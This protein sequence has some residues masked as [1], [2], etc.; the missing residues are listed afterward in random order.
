MKQGHIDPNAVAVPD[1]GS[2]TN[3]DPLTLEPGSQGAPAA[4][5]APL[6]AADL[7]PAT[8]FRR[9][10]A[11]A[12]LA[13]P[14]TMSNW[15][16]VTADRTKDGHPIAVMGPQ[17]A[18]FMPQILMD[19]DVHAPGIAA[20]GATFP[21]ISLYVLLGRGPDFAWSATS[22][23][24]DETDVRA[25]EL[26]D[27]QGGD[28]SPDSTYYLFK[29][30]C[31]AMTLRT[32]QWLSKPTP[33]GPGLPTL[34]TA[35][36]QRTI[37][38]PLIA[39]ATVGGKPVAYVSQRST[40]DAE[41]D[42]AV[43][44]DKLNSGFVH[45]ATSFK[46]AMSAMTGSFNWLY[47]DAKDVAYYH[48]GLYPVRAPGIATDLPSWGTG[49]WEWQGVVTAAHH[50]QAVNPAK[51]WLDSWNNKPA[52]EWNSS[53]ATYGFGQV[54]RVEM[55][56]TRL[57][58]LVAAGDVTPAGVVRAMADAATVDLRGQES[59]R[60]V[61]QV[62]GSDPELHQYM[63]ILADWIQTGA[64]RVDRNGDGQYD[65]QAAVALMDAWWTPLVEAM[66]G[67][68]MSGLFDA[69][70]MGFDDGNRLGG[71]GSS[72]QDEYG[73]VQKAAQMALGDPVPQPYRVLRCADGTLAGCRSAIRESLAQ[74]VAE[75]GP[76]PA[77]WDA[78]EA[79]DSILY[80]AVGLITLDPQPWQ[81]RPTFQQVVQVFSRAR[82]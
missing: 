51:G 13:V 24:S 75:L 2:V 5:P 52:H 36:V 22:G 12:G 45:D 48:S 66:F 30:Q 70:P 33:G 77:T 71:L 50:P 7:N 47:V 27:P 8:L 37:H 18:Y 4:K 56:S 14:D 32:D 78:N 40:F 10:M 62:L 34:V 6:T 3:Y 9:A 57:E 29:G 79:G 41:L 61:L 64:H 44:F 21:G 60:S 53:D 69:W 11:R 35:N 54:H 20:R 63:Q 72:F 19:M 80:T 38:G 23:D 81:N 16:G 73:Y 55:L 28:P 26:C 74:V 49:Q 17:V 58:P 31:T 39:R 15:L 67:P 68:Q 65:D 76:D 82:R 1:A 43:A 46:R 42:S 59:M 25:E